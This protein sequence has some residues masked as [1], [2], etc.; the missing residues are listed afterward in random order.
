MNAKQD[1]TGQ[2]SN[3][4]HIFDT[5][6]RDGEQSPGCSMNVREKLQVAKALDELGVDVIEAGFPAASDGDFESVRAVGALGLAAT[7]CGLS[8]TRQGDMEAVARSLDGA[9]SKRLHIF[10]ATSPIHREFKLNMSKQQIIDEMCKAMEF[11]RQHFDDIEVTAE[12]AG[13]TEIDYLTE[14]FQAA[15]EAGARVLNVPDTVGYVTPSE[16]RQLYQHLT[17]NLRHDGSVILSCHNHNDL[18]LAVANSLGAIE[19]GARQVECTINGIGERAGN[20]SLE[21]VVMA[22]RTRSDRYQM[23][24]GIDTTRLYP[25]SRLVS[26]VTGSRVQPNKAIVGRNAFAHEAGIHQDGMLKNSETYEIMKPETVGV[27]ENSLVLGKHSGRHAFRDR[28]ETLGFSVNKEQ[29]EELFKEF[30]ALADRKKSVYDEDIEAL[31]LGH[32]QDGPW[33]LDAISIHTEIADSDQSAEASVKLRFDGQA[34]RVFSGRGDGPVN[35][36]VNAIKSCMDEDLHVEEFQVSAVS[37][38]SDAQGRAT[39]KATVGASRYQGTGVSTDIVEA[40]ARALV[41]IMNRHQQHQGRSI[42]EPALKAA[43]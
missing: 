23:Q 31:V 20:C 39:V 36:I 7:I 27:P 8:R 25:C 6:L 24:T 26:A 15:I 30:K 2:N 43:I 1:S 10:I 41:S 5:T 22:L 11:G 18:G 17:D 13:R 42:A 40:S 16:A 9:K 28:L 3:Y 29:L 37:G 4:V 33:H 38:G 14:Y 32:E 34:P 35:A 21:E 19:G 12:D